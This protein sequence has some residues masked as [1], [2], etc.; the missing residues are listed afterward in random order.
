MAVA[1]QTKSGVRRS[2]PRLLDRE[3]VLGG[4]LVLPAL[5][6]VIAF[7][8]LP[9]AL[10]FA[11]A[12]MR[13][14]LT[15]SPDWTFFGLGNFLQL[16]RDPVL[17]EA[18]PRTL[19]FAFLSTTVT[20]VAGVGV[21]L[22]LNE[23]FRGN[24]SMRVLALLPWAVAPIA[25]GVTWKLIFHFLYGLLNGILFA[26]GLI[27]RYVGWLEDEFLAFHAAV[28]AYGWLA[29]PFV[30]LILL[31]RLQSIPKPL[32][33]AA[34]VDGAGQWNRFR[35]VTLPGIRGTLIILLLFQI[36]VSMQTF[37]L[38]Y[39][40]TRGGPGDA[41]TVISMV[42]Y[43]RAFDELRFGYASALALLLFLLT[44]VVL[45]AAFLLARRSRTDSS[46]ARAA[47]A[48]ITA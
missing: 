7:L 3:G 12:F 19:Y 30:S 48:D 24:R 1:E 45:G 47:A 6:V 42:I 16:P 23:P 38:L 13:I 41:T 4:I 44:I 15:R 2:A 28:L 5:V 31:A 33:R 17:G 27:P 32:Y 22:F 40:L 39:S 26:L 21:A 25:T 43:N 8:V 46:G 14:D 35:Y 20:L 10:A 29:V 34:M 11:M 36:I 37:D 9:I 18:V